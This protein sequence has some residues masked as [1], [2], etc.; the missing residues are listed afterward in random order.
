MYVRDGI[1]QHREK[2]IPVCRMQHVDVLQGPLER[3]FGL[4]GLSVFTAGGAHATFRLTG[5]RLERAHALRDRILSAR[6]ADEPE[7]RIGS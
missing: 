4:A 2:V 6:Q 5:L 3:R 7:R 1:L